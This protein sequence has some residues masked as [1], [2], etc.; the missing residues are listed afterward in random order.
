MEDGQYIARR[1][2]ETGN[3]VAMDVVKVYPTI[4][5]PGVQKNVS[6]ASGLIKSAL[7]VASQ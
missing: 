3:L 1:I 2:H 6:C 7:K 5:L 4:Y